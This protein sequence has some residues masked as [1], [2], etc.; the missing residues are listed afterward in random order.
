MLISKIDVPFI[1]ISILHFIVFPKYYTIK[2]LIFVVGIFFILFIQVL[3]D[4]ISEKLYYTLYIS[5]LIITINAQ[6]LINGQ[7]RN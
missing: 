2:K 4:F 6:L 5:T 1:A 7:R 3:S